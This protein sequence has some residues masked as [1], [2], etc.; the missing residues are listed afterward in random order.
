MLL[1]EIVLV[2]ALVAWQGFVFW[3]NRQLTD[4]VQAMYPAAGAVAVQPIT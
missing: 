1:I 4:R 2:L 3:H